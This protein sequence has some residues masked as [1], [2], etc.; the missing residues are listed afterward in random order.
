MRVRP[1][2]ELE[3]VVVP[4]ELERRR[5]GLVG[6]GPIAPAVVEVGGPVLQEHADGPPGLLA[7]ERRVD[8]APADAHEAA[9]VADDLA[10]VVRPLPGRGEGADAAGARA[11]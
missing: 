5:H 6:E 3:P 9:D 11:A 7:D 2:P 8:V 1:V 10:K 4:A